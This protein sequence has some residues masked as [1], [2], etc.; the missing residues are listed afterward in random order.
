MAISV[1]VISDLES[2]DKCMRARGKWSDGG[3]ILTVSIKINER[4]RGCLKDFSRLDA[5]INFA[6]DAVKPSW[7]LD[8]IDLVLLVSNLY[9]ITMNFQIA[10]F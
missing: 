5:V 9:S 10:T 6:C 4:E 2:V 3:G 1:C 7:I 8:R